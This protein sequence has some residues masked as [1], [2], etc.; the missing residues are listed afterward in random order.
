MGIGNKT[1]SLYETLTQ[2]Q[3]LSNV[4]KCNNLMLMKLTPI[5]WRAGE[6]WANGVTAPGIQRRGHPNSEIQTLKC[7]N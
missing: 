4:E 7:C 2:T 1:F 5:Q 3:M 6:G